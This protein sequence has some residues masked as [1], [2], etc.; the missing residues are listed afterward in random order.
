MNFKSLSAAVAAMVLLATVAA[1]CSQP[2]SETQR[3]PSVTEAEKSSTTTAADDS[4]ETTAPKRPARPKGEPFT[5]SNKKGG[6]EEVMILR[7]IRI[8]RHEDFERVVLEFQ[9]QAGGKQTGIPIWTSDAGKIP[10]RD[11][12]GKQTK[13]SG[14]HFIELRY[15]GIEADLSQGEEPVIIYKGPKRFSPGFPSISEAVFSPSYEHNTLILLI[16]LNRPKGYRVSELRS[17]PR[18]ILDVAE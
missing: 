7:D 16:G 15:H 12:E 11:P 8:A 2:T 9:S 17:P 6:T 4:P 5:L 18:I 13:V 3:S 14:T 10:Y 1:S